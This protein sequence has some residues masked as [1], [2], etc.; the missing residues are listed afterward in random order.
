MAKKC[1]SLVVYDPEKN[2][3]QRTTCNA[4][5]GLEFTINYENRFFFF[6]QMMLYTQNHRPID[7]SSM[8]SAYLSM[9][10]LVITAVAVGGAHMFVD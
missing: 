8:P 5:H 6:R 9:T 10:H 3:S 7:T 2:M 1:Y 4:P